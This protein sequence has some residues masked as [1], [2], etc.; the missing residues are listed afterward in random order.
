[1]HDAERLARRVAGFLTERYPD[2]KKAAIDEV[3]P[4]IAV[5]LLNVPTQLATTM[6]GRKKRR[7]GDSK[8]HL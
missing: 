3:A 1:M 2:V 6:E 4:Q 8:Y 7:K 5:C